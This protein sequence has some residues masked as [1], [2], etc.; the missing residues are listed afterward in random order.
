M[1]DWFEFQP[2]KLRS[3]EGFG[4]LLA[5]ENLLGKLNG[6]PEAESAF[7]GCDADGICLQNNVSRLCLLNHPQRQLHS[8]YWRAIG[9]GFSAPPVRAA[10]TRRMISL[11]Q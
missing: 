4:K 2:S 10:S 7:W 1:D 11:L 5:A 9:L 6:S 3:G 8:Q